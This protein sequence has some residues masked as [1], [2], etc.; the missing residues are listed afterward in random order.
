LPLSFLF[1]D[2]SVYVRFFPS[3]IFHYY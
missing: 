2:C 1:C 3:V